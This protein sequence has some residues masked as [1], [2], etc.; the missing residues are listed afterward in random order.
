MVHPT[1]LL[2]TDSTGDEGSFVAPVGDY[3][4]DVDC[5]CSALPCLTERL[6][7]EKYAK[8]KYFIIVLSLVG[9]F[10][11]I[12]VKYFRGTSQIWS[13]HYD[14]PQDTIDW[15]IYINEVFVG[16]FALLV[17]YW[18]NRIHR[19][20]W[21]GALTI[22]LGVSCITLA[23]PEI[24]QPF[25]KDETNI[26]V[27]NGR[28]LCQNNRLSELTDL[29]LNINNQIVAFIILTL[30]QILFAL[31]TISFITHGVTY[32]DDNISPGQS[33]AYIALVF[34]AQRMGK[35]M[36]I[37]S[38]WMPFLYNSQS[39]FVSTIWLIVAAHGI[40][41]GIVLA[42][43][44]KIMPNTLLRKSVNSLLS[45]ASGNP[46]TEPKQAVD[47]F[48]ISLWRVLKNKVL[49][50][51]I[52]T[53]MFMQAAIVNFN[54]K[55][56]QF[57]QSKYHV[58]RYNDASGYSDPMLIQF[59]TNYLKQPLIAVAYI[60]VG[61][62]IAK[63]QPS[64][65]Y[66]VLW[67]IKVFVMVLIGFA[68]IRFLN[69]T[70]KLKNELEGKLTIPYCS[71]DCGCS[72]DGPFQP[73]CLNAQTR[74]SPCWAGC[75]SFDPSLKIY[76]NCT[77]G[78]N[79]KTVASE[80]SCDADNCSTYWTLAQAQGVISS[81]LLGTTFITSLIINLRCVASKDKALAVALH[82]TFLSIF[83]YLPVKAIYDASADYF[84]QMWGQHSCQFH[85][86]N[87]ALFLVI[88]T[89]V[90][91][92][93]AILLSIALFFFVGKIELYTNSISR[94]NSNVSF[95][96][97]PGLLQNTNNPEVPTTSN[98]NRENDDTDSE[99]GEASALV[100]GPSD[101]ILRNKQKSESKLD[102][103]VDRS[104]KND[105]IIAY[106]SEGDL[107]PP[108]K[109]NLKLGKS[110]SRTSNSNNSALSTD[111]SLSAIANTVGDD[112]DSDFSSLQRPQR[113][114]LQDVVS[115]HP[116]S[117][118]VP[119]TQHSSNSGHITETEF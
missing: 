38:A 73:I 112:H 37:Y 85:S 1:E 114:K 17:A 54:M 23:I 31:Y 39:I 72:L 98:Q 21:L 22:Y 35:Q 75:T 68:G 100:Q 3:R 110:A 45:L 29:S 5:G 79:G 11:G 70:N 49:L 40:L 119:Q 117:K 93:M 51:N 84:C 12:A 56:K 91:K 74:F 103:M 88:T 55:E 60:S 59:T 78:E 94:R 102:K 16:I 104:S 64:P 67:N 86:D 97:R 7:L 65:K 27:V 105:R 41:Y 48:F 53:M 87:F 26:S 66:L 81:A 47:G 76:S 20:T 30:Y 14:I 111:S 118:K 113:S 32:I 34:A 83:P 115:S 101:I 33:P 116:R 82:L 13:Q 107:V 92:T 8:P 99:S 58:S 96:R 62:A 108:L 50:L 61:M 89:L 106:L 95:L 2:R 42:M 15:L 24:Y 43:F 90:L 109:S 19:P 52:I 36:G 63:M 46:P 10:N 77:C 9:V 25:N 18:G 6:N 57:N 69:C 71:W 28:I 44:P 80:G 4:N